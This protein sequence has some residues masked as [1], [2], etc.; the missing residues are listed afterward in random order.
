M[1][2]QKYNNFELLLSAASELS[3]EAEID[4]FLAID[5]SE[6][7][8]DERKMRRVQRL[9]RGKHTDRKSTRLNSSHVT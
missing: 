3:M 9:I 8:V 5:P 7:E 6:V 4:A 2:K 1:K